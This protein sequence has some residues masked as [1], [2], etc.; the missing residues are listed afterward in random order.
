MWVQ[1]L[2]VTDFQVSVDLRDTSANCQSEMWAAILK[3]EFTQDRPIW[4]SEFCSNGCTVGLW[5]CPGDCEKLNISNWKLSE[6]YSEW[7]S[8]RGQYPSDRA[9]SKSPQG[10]YDNNEDATKWASRPIPAYLMFTATN[11]TNWTN[12]HVGYEPVKEKHWDATSL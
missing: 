2:T 10:F 5:Y 4:Q 7:G 1:T 9:P 6:F 8:V 12:R 11:L 3:A